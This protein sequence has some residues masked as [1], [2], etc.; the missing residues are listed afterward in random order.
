MRPLET[1]TKISAALM[2]HPVSAET[3]AKIGAIQKAHKQPIGTTS[4][5][6]YGYV[7][8]KT[9]PRVR[10]FEHRLVYEAVNGPIPGGYVIHH[11]DGDKRNNV[12]SNLEMLTVG[13]HMRLHRVQ[14]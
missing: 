4:E 9:A 10:E 7:T 1:R 3:R 8:R 6:S 11:V 12:L 13:E 2:G 14:N 5:S